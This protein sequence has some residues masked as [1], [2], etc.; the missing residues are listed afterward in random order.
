[1]AWKAHWVA[2]MAAAAKPHGFHLAHAADDALVLVDD[3]FAD[4]PGVLIDL[5]IANGHA[6][7]ADAAADEAFAA[8]LAKRLASKAA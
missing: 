1:M 7:S 8:A 4:D 6:A 3:R 5:G 2:R